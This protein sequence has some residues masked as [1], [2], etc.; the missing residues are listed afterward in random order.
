MNTQGS[1]RLRQEIAAK[2]NTTI[3]SQPI[4]WD[5]CTR[6]G[7]SISRCSLCVKIV[8][9]F[10][11]DELRTQWQASDSRFDRLENHPR[12]ISKMSATLISATP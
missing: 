5:P 4:Q 3:G 8:I 11:T 9:L 6:P 10:R 7:G 1:S 12:S 2:G